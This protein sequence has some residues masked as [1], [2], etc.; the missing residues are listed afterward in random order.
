MASQVSTGAL[1]A[2][3]AAL[4]S[5]TIKIGLLKNTYS[6]NPDHKFVSDVNTHECGVSGYTGGFGGAGRKT[7]ASKTIS[8][9][10]TNNRAVFDAADP[11]TWSALAAGETLRYAFVCKEVTNDGASP[12]LAVLDFGADKPTNGSDISIQ[13]NSLGIYYIQC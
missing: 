12:L 10:T 8:E 7:L 2:Y 13:I 9:D 11:A 1:V 3:L 5:D 4:A 6:I